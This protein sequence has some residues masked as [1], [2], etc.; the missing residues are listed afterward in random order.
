MSFSAG[1]MN[2]G[3]LRSASG[4]VT[5]PRS[6]SWLTATQVTVPGG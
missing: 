1:V 3:V 4:T 5:M 6:V 2:T